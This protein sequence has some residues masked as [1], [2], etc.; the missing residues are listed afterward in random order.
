MGDGAVGA[1]G[2]VYGDED[3]LDFHTKD[4]LTLFIFT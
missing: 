3:V 1:F 2:T 4:L